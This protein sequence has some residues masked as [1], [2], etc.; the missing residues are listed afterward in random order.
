M[1][2][3]VVQL[4]GRAFLAL[5]FVGI[6]MRGLAQDNAAP[7]TPR[8][9][10][11]IDEN[12]IAHYTADPR[13][14]PRPL[15]SHLG[16]LAPPSLER[17]DLQ[18]HAPPPSPGPPPG[19]AGAWIPSTGGP[20]TVAPDAWAGV[21]RPAEASSPADENLPDATGKAS[22]QSQRDDLD[23]RIAALRA[24]IAADEDTLKAAVSTPQAGTSRP[25]DATFREVSRRLPARLA[26]LRDLRAQRKNLES[27]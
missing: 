27:E 1:Q 24:D 3:R 8:I 26:E 22:L 21:D 15:R 25:D 5:A 16:E 20:E 23:L 18:A 4:L 10:R 11:W 14:V 2:G 6:P 13:Q 7:P 19:A 9:Y 17:P 12:G